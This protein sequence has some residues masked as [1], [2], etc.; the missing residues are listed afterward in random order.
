MA[1]LSV[2]ARTL[3]E[4]PGKRELCDVLVRLRDRHLG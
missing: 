3:A 2:T 4:L 1:S